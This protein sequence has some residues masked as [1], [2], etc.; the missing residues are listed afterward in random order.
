M[1]TF[2]NIWSLFCHSV[3]VQFQFNDIKSSLLCV[4]IPHFVIYLSAIL[5]SKHTYDTYI[6]QSYY[7][8]CRSFIW[9]GSDIYSPMTWGWT[10]ICPCIL[11]IQLKVWDLQ[12]ALYYF[13]SLYTMLYTSYKKQALTNIF[14]HDLRSVGIYSEKWITLKMA[15]VTLFWHK[16]NFNIPDMHLDVK[17]HG[18]YTKCE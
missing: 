12:I 16:D 14:S 3:V 13:L 8:T 7:D 9:A 15:Q 1:F 5:V 17:V 11:E 4:F 6:L 2:P 18:H 10:Q